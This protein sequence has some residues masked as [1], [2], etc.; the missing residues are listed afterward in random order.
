MDREQ[1]DDGTAREGTAVHADGP[2]HVL[3]RDATLSM[4]A[5]GL[6]GPTLDA[7]AQPQFGRKTTADPAGGDGPRYQYLGELGRGGMGEVKLYRDR[8]IGREVAKKTLRLANADPESPQ[9]KRFLREARVQGQLEHPGIVP[10]HDL[11]V[12]SDGSL[13]F[14]MKRIRGTSLKEVIRGLRENQPEFVERYTLHKLLSAFDVVCKAVHFSHTRNVLHRDLKPANIMLGDFGE[15]YV[16]DWGLAKVRGV[17]E[18]PA[19]ETIAEASSADDSQTV[20]G[21]VMGTP[22]Y[23]APEQFSGRVDELDERTDVYALGIILFEILTLQRFHFGDDVEELRWST[24]QEAPIRASE[25]CPE[26]DIAP[27]LDAI[28]MRA[29]AHEP[30][31]RFPGVRAL[32]TAVERFLE[33]DR[34][35]EMRRDMAR[36][37]ANVASEALDRSRDSD[38]DEAVERGRAMRAVTTALGLDP[39]NREALETLVDM[40]TTPPREL[41][42]E[43]QEEM[44]SSIK[45]K[46]RKAAL[47]AMYVYLGFTFYIPFPLWMGLRSPLAFGL[48]A[49]AIASAALCSYLIARKPPADGGVPLSHV[50]IASTTVVISAALVGPFIIVPMLAFA[51]TTAYIATSGRKRRGVVILAGC[52]AVLLPWLLPVLG[53]LPETF[54]VHDGLI[55]IA[56][57]MVDFPAVATTVFLLVSNIVMILTGALYV[58]KLKDDFDHAERALHVQAWQLRQIVPEDARSSVASHM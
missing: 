18:V 45:R 5:D 43:A 39:E 16:L 38:A 37:Q 29:T 14:M 44:L 1:N 30:A 35:L 9:Y 41:P 20:I 57:W 49:A 23:M 17:A 19:E 40:L 55:V 13:Y 24:L 46:N 4:A 6:M 15:V 36:V 3:D 25:R 11:G 58:G 22:G 51:N 12:E 47:R 31:D 32:Y 34:D 26:R 7:G 27:E 21:S 50:L 10:V 2:T 53:W 8:I 33:G 48:L 28:C 52:L 54:L 42:S 56:P